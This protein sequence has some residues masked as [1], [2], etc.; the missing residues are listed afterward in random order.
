ML[1]YKK[2]ATDEKLIELG[3]REN[4]ANKE[5]D[6]ITIQYTDGRFSE[7]YTDDFSPTIPFFHLS[8]I[9]D[10]SQAEDSKIYFDN[11][12]LIYFIQSTEDNAVDNNDKCIPPFGPEIEVTF[13]DGEVLQGIMIESRPNGF[14]FFLLTDQNNIMRKVFVLDTAIKKIRDLKINHLQKKQI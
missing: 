7:G 9:A 8:Q 12:K 14:G 3:I 1:N 10:K 11:I 5:I 4:I 6:I 13:K 2:E